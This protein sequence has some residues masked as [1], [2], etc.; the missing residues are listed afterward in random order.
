MQE[1]KYTVFCQLNNKAK[2]FISFCGISLAGYCQTMHSIHCA[3]Q[4]ACIFLIAHW[5]A[6]VLPYWSSR[7]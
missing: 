4:S 5:L 6:F 7:G 1:P 2:P 3:Q